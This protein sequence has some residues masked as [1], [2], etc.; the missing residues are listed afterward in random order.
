MEVLSSKMPHAT[1]RTLTGNQLDLLLS[2]ESGYFTAK[3]RT[4]LIS[5]RMRERVAMPVLTKDGESIR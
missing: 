5:R 1:N 3:G 4:N 2:S